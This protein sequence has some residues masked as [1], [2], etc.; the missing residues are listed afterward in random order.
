M[1]QVFLAHLAFYMAFCYN[2]WRI[3]WRYTWGASPF[4]EGKRTR[5][6]GMPALGPCS[7]QVLGMYL[8]KG[9]TPRAFMPV[10][11]VGH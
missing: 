5:K 9:L 8:K 7:T 1:C 6:V 10:C 11:Q 3:L 2:L 4:T